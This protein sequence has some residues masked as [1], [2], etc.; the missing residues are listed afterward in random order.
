MNEAREQ[1]EKEADRIRLEWLSTLRE[2][3]RRRH[4]ALDFRYQVK[5]HFTLLAALAA[6]A[7]AVAAISVAVGVTR[8]RSRNQRLLAARIN[9]L[10]RAW[11]NPEDIAS[12]NSRHRLPQEIGRKLAVALAVAVGT[13]LAKR[14]ANHF[15]PA[16][17]GRRA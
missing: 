12:P 4:R 9:G 13:R 7:V 3:D 2:L 5:R 17:S 8:V 14:G 15:L 16:S 10:I 1:S 6:G 11:Q